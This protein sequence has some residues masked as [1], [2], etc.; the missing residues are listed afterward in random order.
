MFSLMK[1]KQQSLLGVDISSSSIKL[2]QLSSHGDGNYCVEG[3]GKLSLSEKVIDGALVK[4]INVVAD[5]IKKIISIGHLNCKQAAVAV[6]DSSTISK[7]IQIAEGLSEN[8]IEELVVIEADKYIPYPIDEINIDFSVIGPSPKNSALQDVLI[9]AARAE[10]VN[11][12]LEALRLAGLE[13]KI[14]DVESYVVERAAQL[15]K[16]TLPASGENKV[17]AIIDIGAKYSHLFV[18]QNMKVIYTRDEEFGGN[19]LIEEIV[20]EYGMT[21]SAALDALEQKSLPE[22]Y[23]ERILTPFYDNLYIQVRRALQ[24]FFSTSSHNHVDHIVLVGGIA[25]LPEIAPSLQEQL[26]IT[27]S[28]GDPLGSMVF[29][30]AVDKELI[31]SESPSLMIACGLA[32]RNVE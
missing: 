30:P 17:I 1:P 28:I 16:S 15:F 23:V 4:D 29:D 10:L 2:L 14:V 12:R 5:T 24:F 9:V 7:M 25:K 22:D 13:T 3:Y 11:T 26:K 6:P 8:D 32:L 19:Q 18:L 31:L 27:T 20:R 21:S